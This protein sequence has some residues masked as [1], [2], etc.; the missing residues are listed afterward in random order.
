MIFADRVS[1]G[2]Y[3]GGAASAE[4]G[5]LGGN[6][7]RMGGGGSRI[8]CTAETRMLLHAIG[9]CSDGYCNKLVEHQGIA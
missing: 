1:V 4:D 7:Y 3:R 2:I 8:V 9:T 6:F 5:M